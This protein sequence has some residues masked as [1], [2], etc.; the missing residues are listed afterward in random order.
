MTRETQGVI[1]ETKNVMKLAKFL[2]LTP[3]VLVAPA[4][5]GETV[6][7]FYE[8]LLPKSLLYLF[9]Y[10]LNITN[11]VSPIFTLTFVR[12]FRKE[13][14]KLIRKFKIGRGILRFLKISDQQVQQTRTNAF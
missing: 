2:T 7:R 9:A 1:R 8:D 14:L 5:L 12:P 13:F 3:I 11:A 4:A 10:P 6:F